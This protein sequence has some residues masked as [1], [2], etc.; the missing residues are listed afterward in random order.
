M[1]KTPCMKPSSPI[2]WTLRRLEICAPVLTAGSSLVSDTLCTLCSC[3]PWQTSP[4][5]DKRQLD[6][7]DRVKSQKH[8]CYTAGSLCQGY[9]LHLT[10][11]VQE[12]DHLISKGCAV[13]ACSSMSRRRLQRTLVL[14]SRTRL[15]PLDRT[16]TPAT[17]SQCISSGS[18]YAVGV[19]SSSVQ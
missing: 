7:S 19:E 9:N 17:P 12:N 14:N 13:P 8:S 15:N 3:H 11:W 18:H 16:C 4:Y 1:V 2:I 5:P 6:L 10:R